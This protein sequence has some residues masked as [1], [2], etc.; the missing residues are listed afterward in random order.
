MQVKNGLCYDFDQT[1]RESGDS[2]S[3]FNL[4]EVSLDIE[5]EV[6][7]KSLMNIHWFIK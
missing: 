5:D 4:A 6:L 1:Q 7:G 2:S 3:R